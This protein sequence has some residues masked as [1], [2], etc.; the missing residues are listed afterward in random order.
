MKFFHTSDWHF[1]KL[2]QGVYM[3]EDQRYVM[4]EF[5]KAIENEKAGCGDYCRGFI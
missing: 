2:V 5:I 3:T 1:G 4:Q